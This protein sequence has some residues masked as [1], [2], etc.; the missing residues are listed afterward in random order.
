M[1]VNR[2]VPF[3]VEVMAGD[4][5]GGKIIIEDFDTGRVGV[6]IEFASDFEAGLGLCC[7]NQLD[8]DGMTDEGL[9][10]PVAGDEG[11]QAVLDP[12]PFAC[13]GRQ[14]AHGDRHA[15]IV[16]KLLQFELPEADARAVGAAA[17]GVISRLLASG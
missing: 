17:V 6:G 1:W 3:A 16:G 12:V 2:V 10:A 15:E 4:F 7:R 13:A 9:A 14:V 11:E 8:D 5:D